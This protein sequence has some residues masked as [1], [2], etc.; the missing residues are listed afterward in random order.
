MLCLALQIVKQYFNCVIL[1]QCHLY[2]LLLIV[3][4]FVHFHQVLSKLWLRVVVL[5]GLSE[6]LFCD[7]KVFD[8]FI[9]Y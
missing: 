1:V 4:L 9:G 6:Y 7:A 2:W 8:Y 3:F 5:V